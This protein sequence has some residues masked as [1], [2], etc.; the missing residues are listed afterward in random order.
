[1]YN[2]SL[3]SR[4]RAWYPLSAHAR[5]IPKILGDQET[6]VNLPAYLLRVIYRDMSM[7]VIIAEVYMI[8]I[9]QL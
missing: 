6:P 7:N 8:I 3:E 2:V 4:P 1:M 9:K 5:S